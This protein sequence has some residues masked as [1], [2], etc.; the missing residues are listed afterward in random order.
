MN[1]TVL[2]LSDYAAIASE[3]TGLDVDTV[4]SV[5]KLDLADSALQA[6]AAGFGDTEFYPGFVDKAAVLV[7]TLGGEHRVVHEKAVGEDDHVIARAA[8]LVEQ[9]L[10]VHIGVR[11]QSSPLACAMARPYAIRSFSFAVR[12]DASACMCGN[13][14]CP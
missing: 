2:D 1:V 4:M 6:P 9:A 7:R 13:G 3:I 14:G 11:H 10:A 12:R 5:A 8:V